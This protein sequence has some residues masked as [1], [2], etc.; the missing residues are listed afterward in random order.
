MARWSNDVAAAEALA[1]E[2]PAAPEAQLLLKL[3]GKPNELDKTIARRDEAQRH[4]L[5][6]SA[7]IERGEYK[8]LPRFPVDIIR[9]KGW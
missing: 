8:P 6:F 2:N 7:Q 3:M 1:N 9:K 4:L 5:I